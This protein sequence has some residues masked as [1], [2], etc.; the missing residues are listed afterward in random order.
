[1][2]HL[3]AF[4]RFFALCALTFYET[5]ATV[6]AVRRARDPVAK[7]RAGVSRVVS[8]SRRACRL[9]GIQLDVRGRAPEG[10][11]VLVSNH[12]SYIDIIV[13][14]QTA[15]PVFVAKAEISRWPLLGSVTDAAG[16]VYID[17]SRIRAIPEVVGQMDAIREA[18]LGVHFFPE[19]TTTDGTRV[20]EFRPALLEFAAR[21]GRPVHWA[22]LRY[23]TPAGW[24]KASE[25]VCW[26]GDDTFVGHLWGLLRLPGFKATVHFGETPVEEAD[27]KV[28]ARTLEDAVRNALAPGDGGAASE[29]R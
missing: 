23:E 16:T 24:P 25:S 29:G 22:A 6:V 1:M 10:A 3:R 9:L 21:S 17:R 26:W 8:W 12:L 19:G 18:G 2:S 15:R 7:R 5:V 13:L 27:R 14:G 11:Y 4:V 20:G 28:L